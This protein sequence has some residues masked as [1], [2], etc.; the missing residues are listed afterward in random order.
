M[1]YRAK[2]VA[3]STA[4]CVQLFR[5]QD[6]SAPTRVSSC[7][8]RTS[9][10]PR[11]A[12]HQNIPAGV[13]HPLGLVAHVLGE[14]AVLDELRSRECALPEPPHGDG[15][16]RAGRRDTNRHARAVAEARIED[17]RR[18]RV[19]AQGPGDMNRR[20]LQ[21]RGSQPRRVNRP[22]PAV[23]FEPDVPRPVDHDF[24]H[25][26]IVERGLEPRQ[27]RLIRWWMRV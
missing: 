25:V 3:Q 10:A 2:A 22:Q 19:Q 4:L 24:A 12:A 27:E 1:R 26:G 15:D 8:T 14:R 9:S 5:T 7:C 16:G 6:T 20:P 21:R 11:S 18:S 23:A 13:Q 17:R